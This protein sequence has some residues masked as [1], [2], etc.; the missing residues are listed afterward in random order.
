MG[1]MGSGGAD[2]ARMVLT[3]AEEKLQLPLQSLLQSLIERSTALL[4]DFTSGQH[5]PG[6]LTRLG[7]SFSAHCKHNHFEKSK[8]IFSSNFFKLQLDSFFSSSCTVSISHPFAAR[9]APDTMLPVLP[10]INTLFADPSSDGRGGEGE[11]KPERRRLQARPIAVFFLPLLFFWVLSEWE[12]LL[13]IFV[14]IG[15]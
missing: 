4:P 11:E 15:P 9:L 3:A 2:V 12:R 10:Y 7:T 1:L 5:L 6:L 8:Y 14:D 13:L